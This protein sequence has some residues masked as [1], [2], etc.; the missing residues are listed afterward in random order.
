[1]HARRRCTRSW[2]RSRSKSG[3]RG[4][5][6]TS[7]ARAALPRLLP[8]QPRQ[9]Q[10]TQGASLT[11]P[12]TQPRL[13]RQRQQHL[14][15]GGGRQPWV[16]RARQ[17]CTT[18]RSCPQ[19]WRFQAPWP[20]S[21]RSCAALFGSSAT[22]SRG[23]CRARGAR[24][25]VWRDCWR[26]LSARSTQVHTAPL[27]RM[28]CAH[29]YLYRPRGACCCRPCRGAPAL[30]VRWACRR[31]AGT[32]SGVQARSSAPTPAFAAPFG[33]ESTND[34]AR[35]CARALQHGTRLY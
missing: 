34:C 8:R 19:R 28:G 20:R 31:D 17:A 7:P 30:H 9:R 12:C 35:A 13:L 15:L 18:L 10:Q 29:V 33:S 14:R 2:R 27:S 6:T 22:L 11:T 16:Q 26:T 25:S 21:S 1:M 4:R 24:P 32:H 5:E 3:C 23:A